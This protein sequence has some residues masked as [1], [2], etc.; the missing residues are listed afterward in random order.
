MGC[1]CQWI[2][3][4]GRALES[5]ERLPG[6]QVICLFESDHQ[7]GIE[8]VEPQRDF[9]MSLLVKRERGS[10]LPG[11]RDQVTTAG[12]IFKEGLDSVAVEVG[13]GVSG[14]GSTGSSSRRSHRV[15][16]VPPVQGVMGICSRT[17]IAQDK[18]VSVSICCRGPLCTIAISEIDEDPAKGV[19]QD[20]LLSVIIQ[21]A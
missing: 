12:S 10:S 6:D 16:A 9:K 5:P 18:T 21:E 8:K 1:P 11:I 13:K 17:G 2:T 7:T 19:M 3:D 15:A 14:E 4:D 20:E